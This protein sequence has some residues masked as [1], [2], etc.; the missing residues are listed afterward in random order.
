MIVFVTGGREYDDELT[1]R[2]VL[3]PY[4]P[5]DILIVGGAPGADEIARQ[6]WHDKQLPYV[7]VPAA[8]TRYGRAAGPFRNDLMV[9]GNALSPYVPGLLLPEICHAFAGDRGTEDAVQ[10]AT[11]QE[12]EVIRHR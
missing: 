1:V 4:G 3:S 2:S 5:G 6:T 9:T 10:R 8:W 12:I 11:K 7:V